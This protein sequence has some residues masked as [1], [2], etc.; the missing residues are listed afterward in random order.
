MEE[1]IE[2]IGNIASLARPYTS[3][4]HNVYKATMNEITKIMT[5]LNQGMREDFQMIEE[6]RKDPHRT[7]EIRQSIIASLMLVYGVH[8][9]SFE[10]LDRMTV[11]IDLYE[12]H[13]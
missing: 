9:K 2:I 11:Y 7:R 10:L 13:A 4:E 8:N 12:R 3:L 1:K 6:Y 5:E